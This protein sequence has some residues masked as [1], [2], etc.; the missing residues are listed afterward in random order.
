MKREEITYY[1]TI[2]SGWL[3][4]NEKYILY[5]DFNKYADIME[6]FLEEQ[7]KEIN[8]LI[9]EVNSLQRQLENQKMKTIEAQN[10]KTH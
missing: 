2:D 8:I 6:G 5:S 1:T 7:S 10:A 4:N 9:D 3:D